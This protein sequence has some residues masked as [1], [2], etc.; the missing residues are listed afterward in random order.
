[1]FVFH[2]YKMLRTNITLS[3]LHKWELYINASNIYVNF[4]FTYLSAFLLHLIIILCFFFLFFLILFF[5]HTSG[6]TV[7]FKSTS[8]F[9]RYLISVLYYHKQSTYTDIYTTKPSNPS[10]RV[11]CDTSSISK[12]STVGFSSIIFYHFIILMGRVFANGPGDWAS[13]N[14][15]WCRLA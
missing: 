9:L 2:R 6:Y 13:K 4:F 8:F 1:M 3:E 12:P 14:V 7:V 11:K 15:T 5:K 10:P